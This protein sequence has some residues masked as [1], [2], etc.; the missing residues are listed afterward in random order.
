MVKLVPD[1]TGRFRMRPYFT[2]DELD[3]NCERIIKDHLKKRHGG[4]MFPVTTDDLQVLIEAEAQELDLYADLSFE[5]PAIEGA[6]Y[7]QPAAKPIVKISRKLSTAARRENRLRTTLA[8]EFAHVHYHD[9]LFQKQ[10]SGGR[11][12]LVSKVLCLETRPDDPPLVDWMEWQASYISSSL[13]MPITPLLDRV[14]KAQGRRIWHSVPANTDQ[15]DELC[16]TIASIFQV[17]EIAAQVR[18]STLSVLMAAAP[19][20][21]TLR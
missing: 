18:L 15:A 13:L 14:A 11:N 20:N 16:A 4:V 21:R 5:G 3:R 17:S 9:L 6:T 8:H 10:F 7:F 19:R 12:G 2:A 1:R